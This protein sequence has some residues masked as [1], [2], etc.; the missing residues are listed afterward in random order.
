MIKAFLTDIEGTITRISFVKDIL[1]PYAAKHITEFVRKHHLDSEV[2]EQI[3]AA[4][5]A[6]NQPDAILEDVIKALQH[7]IETDQKITPL[8][9]LQGMIWQHGYHNRDFTGHLY[10]DA[11][12]F[13]QQ[14]Y[15]Q[16]SALYVYSSGSVKAQHLLFEFSDY[17]DIRSLF[18]GY[19]DTLVGGKKTPSSYQNIIDQLP[20]SANEVVFLSDVLDE[21]DAAKAAG[22]HTCHLVRDGQETS[23]EHFSIND[24]T[25][26]TL[27]QYQ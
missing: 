25:A 18:S 15:D 10:P 5:I 20:Y 6:M 8:K 12:Q 24:F 23:S 3:D 2:S 14:Q 17:G 7:W 13:L 19:F 11:Y 22:L 21:L 4:K 26:F 9:Q 27:E 1:F 16:G